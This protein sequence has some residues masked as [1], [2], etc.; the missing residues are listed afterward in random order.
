[1]SPSLD[2][3]AVVK[4]CNGVAEAAGSKAMRDIY[5]CFFSYNL[6]EPGIYLI[7]RDRVECGGGFVQYDEGGV[8]IKCAGKCNFLC[9]TA[10]YFDAF[11][12]KL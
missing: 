6:I 2:N 1:M 12:L 5:R 3:P 9:F 8:L 4:D 7:F 10:G 11:L